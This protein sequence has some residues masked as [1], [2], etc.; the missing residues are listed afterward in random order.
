MA[1]TEPAKVRAIAKHLKQMTDEELSVVIDDAYGEV[2][3][4]QVKEQH[5]ERLSRYL[6]AHLASLNIR[7]AQSEKV[8]DLAKTYAQQS[9]TS[10]GLG[11]TQYGQEYERLL[12]LYIRPS[13]KLTV[14]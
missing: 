14:I 13:L 3:V 6:A 5:E 4:M 9:E 12:K 11:A 7:R 1:K 10:T 8:A 2:K